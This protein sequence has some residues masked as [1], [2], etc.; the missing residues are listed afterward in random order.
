MWKYNET[1]RSTSGGREVTGVGVQIVP[2][3]EEVGEGSKSGRLRRKCHDKEY[4]WSLGGKYREWFLSFSP[5]KEIIVQ[6]L[7]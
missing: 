4:S 3:K 2:L 6:I 5:R 1:A 7:R